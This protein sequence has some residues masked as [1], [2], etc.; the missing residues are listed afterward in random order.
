MHHPLHHTRFSVGY[1]VIVLIAVSL[2]P[3]VPRA[4]ADSPAPPWTAAPVAQFGGALSALAVDEP[5]GIAWLAHGP[6]IVG[7]DVRNPAAPAVLGRTAWMDDTPTALALDGTTGV[8]VTGAYHVWPR[9]SGGDSDEAVQ[10]LDLSDPTTPRVIARLSLPGVRRPVVVAGGIAFVLREMRGVFAEVPFTRIALVSIDVRDP[11]EPRVLAADLLP[12]SGELLDVQVVGHTLAVTS[13]EPTIPEHSGPDYTMLRLFDVTD[14]TNP[15]P[16]A[17]VIDPAW[18]WLGRGPGATPGGPLYGCGITG[19]VALDVAVPAAPTVVRRWPTAVGDVLPCTTNDRPALL[20]DEAG[21]PHLILRDAGGRPVLS[22]FT[23][24]TPRQ[25]LASGQALPVVPTAAAVVGRRAL[26]ADPSGIVTVIDTRALTASGTVAGIVGRLSLVGNTAALA[27]REDGDDG[28]LYAVHNRGGLAILALNRPLDPAILGR[29]V[30]DAYRDGLRA[31]GGH[32]ATAR[33]GLNG[34]LFEATLDQ[35]DVFDVADPAAARLLRVHDGGRFIRWAV[36]PDGIGL[37]HGQSGAWGPAHALSI[38]S[39]AG[40]DDPSEVPL[41]LQMDVHDAAM[42]GSRFVAGGTFPRGASAEACTFKRVGVW[43]LSDL[44]H[45]RSTGHI[46][47]NE[48][49]VRGWKSLRVAEEGGIAFIGDVI[50]DPYEPEVGRSTVWVVA[51]SGASAP[52]VLAQVPITGAITSIAAHKGYVFASAGKARNRNSAV[53]VIDARFP[54]SPHIVGS[55]DIAGSIAV[56]NGR[57]YVS[58]TSMGVWVYE[59]PLDWGPPLGVT[60]LALPWVGAATLRSGLAG[61]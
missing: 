29:Y 8:A 60:R 33:V 56:H 35:A 50:S 2:A 36:T 39:V 16:A 43:D 5:R 25:G 22:A 11:A 24:Q 14:P 28:R 54:A 12:S 3:A 30:D 41:S 37:I 47:L 34:S 45:P 40:P 32:V 27:V 23:S 4:R 31:A 52:R 18:T 57:V 15:V 55:L 17:T 21:T 10:T 13:V 58:T 61:R 38:S 19:V 46:D 1:A 49:C 7:I 6:R 51:T 59:P 44:H 42:A 26:V 53:T 48:R 9:T 20:V